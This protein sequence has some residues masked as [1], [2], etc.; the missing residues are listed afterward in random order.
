MSNSKLANRLTHDSYTMKYNLLIRGLLSKSFIFK[1]RIL[2][3]NPKITPENNS[4][5]NTRRVA[6]LDEYVST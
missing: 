2:F 6:T 3:K 5:C 1:G 4:L